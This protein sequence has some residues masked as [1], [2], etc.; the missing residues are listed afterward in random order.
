M[1]IHIVT[2]PHRTQDYDCVG[3]WNL[4]STGGLVI[5]VSEMG[6]WRKE[7]LVAAH[8]MVEAALCKQRGVAEADVTAWD[9]AYEAQ[10][11]DGD[12][13]EPG[14]DPCCPYR[15]EHI[16]ATKIEQMLA[17]AL[18]VDWAAYSEAIEEL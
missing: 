9:V 2:I 13:S 11:K 10:R 18:G 12:V 7:L 17:E 4:T 6:D 15:A 1:N 3:N 8:E 14:D 16:F 5:S